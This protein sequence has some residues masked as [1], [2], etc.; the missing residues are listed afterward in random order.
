MQKIPGLWPVDF[1]CWVCEVEMINE[2]YLANAVHQ[3]GR[4]VGCRRDAMAIASTRSW[5]WTRRRRSRKL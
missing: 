4:P 3:T 2:H 5:A 1:Q